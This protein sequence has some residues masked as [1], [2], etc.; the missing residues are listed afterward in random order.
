MS[1]DTDDL[2][3]ATWKQEIVKGLMDDGWSALLARFTITQVCRSRYH[4]SSGEMTRSLSVL[5]SRKHKATCRK[6]HG[7]FP[8]NQLHRTVKLDPERP[9]IFYHCL[10]CQGVKNGQA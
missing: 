2:T 10:S 1:A 7:S 5:M 8:L 3:F 9:R 4:V 6:C